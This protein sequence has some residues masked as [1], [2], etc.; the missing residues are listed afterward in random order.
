MKR[1][2]TAGLCVMIAVIG[3]SCDLDLL[4]GCATFSSPAIFALPVDSISG[5]AITEPVVTGIAREG[6][7][8]D[9]TKT[10][11]ETAPPGLAFAW[12][13]PGTYRLEL[14]APGYTTWVLDDIVVSRQGRCDVLQT[15]TVNVRLQPQPPA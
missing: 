7:Y 11:Q 1:M 14:S 15:Y 5:E 2:S 6:A 12:D 13:R 9:T 3:T 10:G 4:G 8:A